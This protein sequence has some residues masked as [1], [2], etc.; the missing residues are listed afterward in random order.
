MK[1]NFDEY[2]DFLIYNK[3]TFEYYLLWGNNSIRLITNS[4]DIVYKIYSSKSIVNELK[5]KL[6]GEVIVLIDKNILEKRYDYNDYNDSSFTL[7]TH[8][9]YIEGVSNS[10][11]DFKDFYINFLHY[12]YSEIEYYNYKVRRYLSIVSTIHEC[13]IRMKN[14]LKCILSS[15]NYTRGYLTFHAMAVSKN[16]NG[17][18][19]IAGGHQGK[20]TLFLSL[21]NRFKPLNDDIIFWKANKDIMIK[22]CSIL[23]S[24]REDSTHFLPNNILNSKINFYEKSIKLKYIFLLEISNE[25]FIFEIDPNDYYKRIMRALSTHSHFDVNEYTLSSI[26]VLF[27]QKFFI[28]KMGAD[29]KKT[30]KYFLNWI[31]RRQKNG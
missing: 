8:K 15:Y 14:G 13:I 6:I 18:L 24:I 12:P 16:N 10:R 21:L 19:F 27:K 28:F 29:Y 31:E 23:P 30:I 5:G 20:T 22:G 17:L 11:Y 9:M 25:N 1:N 7:K 26:K 2:V 3:K 4:Q